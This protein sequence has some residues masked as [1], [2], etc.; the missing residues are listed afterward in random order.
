MVY[1]EAL[2]LPLA[3]VCIWALERRRWVLAG[4]MA[5]LG[6]AVHPVGLLLS[7]VCGVCALRELWRHGPRARDTRLSVLATA[8]SAVGVLSFMGFLWTWTGNPFANYI[9]QHRGWQ[10]KTDPLALVHMWNRLVPSFDPS[11]FNHP[12]VNANLI[13]G[14][15]GAVLMLYELVL[16]FLSR[17]EVSLP[18]IT[19]SLGIVFFACTSEYVPPNPRMVITAF[20]MLMLIARY[21][22]GKRFPLVMFFIVV[23]FVGLS[24]LTF[25]AHVLRP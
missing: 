8:L 22:R 19:W 18:A 9:A 23:L 13:A 1:S 4:V 17:R 12:V 16:L 10:E 21:V 3:A 15:V 20:P 7:V 24:L 11:H 5:G 25:Y 2:L 6:T 14:L